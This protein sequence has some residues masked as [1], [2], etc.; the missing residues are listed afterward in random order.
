M[1]NVTKTIPFNPRTRR[2]LILVAVP[3]LI[4]AITAI[5][6]IRS[7]P[8]LLQHP[9]GAS[10]WIMSVVFNT[11]GSLLATGDEDGNIYLWQVKN[12]DLLHTWS[13]HTD[14][15]TGLAF[16]PDGQA[17]ASAS[18]DGIVSLWE[19]NTGHHTRSFNRSTLIE[20]VVFSSDGRTLI[21]AER[22]DWDS[23]G[24]LVWLRVSDGG[25]RQTRTSVYTGA[26]DNLT[27]SPDGQTLGAGAWRNLYFW[28]A[29]SGDPLRTISHGHESTIVAWGTDN[30]KVASATSQFTGV[31]DVW[32]L[33]TGSHVRTI[34][35]TNSVFLLGREFPLLMSQTSACISVDLGL[36]DRFNC[37]LDTNL[38]IRSFDTSPDGQHIALGYVDGNV[39][40]WPVDTIY[41][42]RPLLL[43]TQTATLPPDTLTPLTATPEHSWHRQSNVAHV[44]NWC[45]EGRFAA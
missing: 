39:R 14:C 15:I 26:I 12:G 5:L 27:I 28:E 33:S 22:A 32:D 43:S 29:A 7:S 2:W 4:V 23:D 20:G 34:H 9:A 13:A 41:T 8:T 30:Q 17:L 37:I 10:A 42:T 6:L 3:L 24:A 40:I 18:Y 45:S 19:A 11:D 1:T 38:D 44:K 31:I 35:S 16:S 21:I 25:V 36:R